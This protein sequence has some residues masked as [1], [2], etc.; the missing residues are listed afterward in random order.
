MD[1]GLPCSGSTTCALGTGPVTRHEPLTP[2][3][4]GDFTAC[5]RPDSDRCERVETER[6]KAFTYSDLISRDRVNLDITW[7][8]ASSADDADRRHP[9]EIAWEIFDDL[10]EALD[11]F[12]SI[13][14]GLG[15]DL[16]ELS[17]D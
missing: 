6:S 17:D 15:S 2:D 10:R 1:R 3:G 16:H 4:L 9:S 8:S 14:D 13:A 7:V 11:E 12:A 5:C